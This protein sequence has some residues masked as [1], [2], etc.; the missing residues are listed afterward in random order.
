MND[1]FLFGSAGEA[2]TLWRWRYFTP[3]EMACQGTGRLYVVPGFMDRLEELRKSFDSPMIV[4]SGYRSEEHNERV[5]STGKT[6]PH[7]TGRAVDI[8]IAGELAFKLHRLAPMHGF[9][10]IG[11]N[12]KGD[13]SG[14]ILHL[15]DLPDGPGC[16]RPRLWSY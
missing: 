5:S 7:T 1:P 10:G 6:G 4:S 16:P 14:R 2:E 13:W 9:T 12:Q 15:D 11:V 3:R 8:L